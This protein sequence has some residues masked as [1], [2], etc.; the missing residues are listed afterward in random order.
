MII[1][2]QDAASIR[3]AAMAKGMRTMLQDGLTKVFLGQ[4]TLDEVFRVAL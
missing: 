1:A 2:R 3:A 4:T